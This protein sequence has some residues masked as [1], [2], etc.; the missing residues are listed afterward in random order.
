M[1][2]LDALGRVQRVTVSRVESPHLMRTLVRSIASSDVVES[3]RYG[4]HN[5]LEQ[6]GRFDGSRTFGAIVNSQI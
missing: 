6:S 4:R 5:L 3:G 2:C 1:V